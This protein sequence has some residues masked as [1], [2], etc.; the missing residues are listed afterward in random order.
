MERGHVMTRIRT[1]KASVADWLSVFARE[2]EGRWRDL[3][4]HGTFLYV[5]RWMDLI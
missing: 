2:E 4:T 5:G 1:K 3:S